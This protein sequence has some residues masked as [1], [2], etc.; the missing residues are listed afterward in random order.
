M[1]QWNEKN[2]DGQFPFDKLCKHRMMP[3]ICQD[4]AKRTM[5]AFRLVNYTLTEQKLTKDVLNQVLAPMIE[6]KEYTPVFRLACRISDPDEFYIGV[7]VN[8]GYAEGMSSASSAPYDTSGWLREPIL[9]PLN[10]RFEFVFQGSREA[11]MGF[12]TA[13]LFAYGSSIIECSRSVGHGYLI[14]GDAKFDLELSERIRWSPELMDQC[15]FKEEPD[16]DTVCVM[17]AE[18]NRND[19]P[20]RSTYLIK[21]K[22]GYED[23]FLAGLRT[24][25]TVAIPCVHRLDVSR[26]YLLHRAVGCGGEQCLIWNETRSTAFYNETFKSQCRVF[27]FSYDIEEA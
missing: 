17:S 1:E 2:V 8:P 14:T 19:Q 27:W 5:N 6:G 16:W 7:D 24:I 23:E 26:F 18:D 25:Q 11:F 9:I 10:R 21:I 22:P 3:S 12:C 4:C 13:Y 20:P 15:I